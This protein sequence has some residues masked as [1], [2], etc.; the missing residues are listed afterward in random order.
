MFLL[1]LGLIGLCVALVPLSYVWGS[2]DP[3]KFS[4]LDWITTL[5]TLDL[6]M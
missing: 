5:L 2:G 6:V 4:K 1:Q 3:D